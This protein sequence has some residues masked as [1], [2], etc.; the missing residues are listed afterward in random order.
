MSIGGGVLM[1]LTVDVAEKPMIY[2]TPHLMLENAKYISSGDT[3]M[4]AITNDNELYTWGNN[5]WGQCGIDPKA[6]V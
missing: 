3:T 4:A 1:A 5:F 6:I 2:K